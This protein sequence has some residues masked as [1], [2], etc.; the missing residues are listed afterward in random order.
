MKGSLSNHSLKEEGILVLLL[1]SL[2][3]LLSEG[4]EGSL[5]SV[6]QAILYIG[7]GRIPRG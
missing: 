3:S 6:L 5:V 1:G 2:V 7:M 4:G